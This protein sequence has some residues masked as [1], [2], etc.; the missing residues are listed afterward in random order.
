MEGEELR[1]GKERVQVHLVGPLE[2]KGMVRKRGCSVEEHER[3][4]ATICARLAYM[5][6]RNLMALADVVERYA[7]GKQRDVWPSEVSICNWACRLQVPPAS[8]SRFVRTYLQSAAGDAAAAGGYLVE[9][10]AHLKKMG[11]PPNDYVLAQMRAD[12]DA[13]RRRLDNI[14]RDHAQGRAS[15]SDLAWMRDYM[16][17]R[18][19]CLDIRAAKVKGAAA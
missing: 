16:A 2:A 11:T 5:T 9:L 15:P 19:L 17:A 3:F 18:Q 12:A 10:L 1:L 7:G 13:N 8:Q 6:E 14:P 4:V